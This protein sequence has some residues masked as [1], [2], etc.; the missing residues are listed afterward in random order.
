M[1]KYNRMA[2]TNLLEKMDKGI[3]CFTA[4]L[5]AKYFCMR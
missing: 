4:P 3:Y 2:N 1:V 5:K